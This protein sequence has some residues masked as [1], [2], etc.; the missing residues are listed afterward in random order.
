MSTKYL[1]IDESGKSKLSDE[2]DFF[3]LTSFIIDKDLHDSI[4]KIM[5]NF[6]KKYSLPTDENIHAYDLFEKEELK[7]VKI[8]IKEIDTFFDHLLHLVRSV[9]FDVITQKINK[10]HLKKTVENKRKKLKLESSKTL[11]TYLGKQGYL[12]ILY[13]ILTTR[14]ILEFSQKLDKE[15]LGEVV[16]ETR[17]QDDLA[18]INAYLRAK[19]TSK[20]ITKVNKNKAKK[21]HEKITTIKFQNKKGLSY[22]LEIADLFSWAKWNEKEIAR[23][24]GYSKAKRGRIK[25]R[26]SQIIDILSEKK[27]KKIE[28]INTQTSK[29]DIVAE[30]VS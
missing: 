24:S 21:A 27:L 4:S 3:I 26:I 1:F 19:D 11:Y 10:T 28:V 15:T 25:K 9:E 30:R 29:E 14:A 13:E 23:S 18:V 2:G 7:S 22:G 20:Y 6:K 17:K 12:D 8:K 5:L 16:A